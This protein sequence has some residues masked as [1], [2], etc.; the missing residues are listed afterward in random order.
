MLKPDKLKKSVVPSI[1]CM[2]STTKPDFVEQMVSA[3]SLG[4]FQKQDTDNTI[5]MDRDP[6]PVGNLSAQIRVERSA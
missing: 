3:I 5:V 1:W 4:I 6:K 2:N